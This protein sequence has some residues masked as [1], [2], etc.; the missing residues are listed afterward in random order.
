MLLVAAFV[1]GWGLASNETTALNDLLFFAFF[2]VL[3]IGLPGA[4]RSR[5]SAIARTSST[6]S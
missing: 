5:S 2:T 6:S 1:T 4:W 3:A